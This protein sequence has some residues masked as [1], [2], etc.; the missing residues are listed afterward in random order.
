M[1]V[2]RPQLMGCEETPQTQHWNSRWQRPQAQCC[3]FKM[4]GEDRVQRRC[5]GHLSSRRRW[6]PCVEVLYLTLKFKM[7]L[8]RGNAAAGTS[9]WSEHLEQGSGCLSLVGTP[10]TYPW[11]EPDSIVPPSQPVRDSC[12]VEQKLPP[13]HRSLFW[14]KKELSFV[15][16]PHWVSFHWLQDQVRPFLGANSGGSLTKLS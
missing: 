5:T 7:A 3:N 2:P 12:T 1:A 13:L 6:V 4:V 16:E 14:L 9:I 11:G 8:V 10:H 15:S